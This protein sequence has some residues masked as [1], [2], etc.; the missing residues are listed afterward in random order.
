MLDLSVIIVSWN[1]RDLLRDCLR[2][3]QAHKPNPAEVI[4]ID[5]ASSDGSPD[6][7]ARE[8]PDVRLIRNTKNVGF[9]RAN[10]QGIKVSH[11]QYIAL[12]NS[13]IRTTAGALKTLV[14]FMAETPA[15]GA[16]GP[17]L[18]QPDGHPQPYAFGKDPTLLYLLHRGL[19]QVLFRR[20]LHDWATDAVQEVDWISG[21]C[22]MV[23]REVIDQVGLLDEHF[24]MYFE[25][26]DWCLRIRKAGWKVYYNPHAEIIHLGGQSL[27]QNPAAQE[28][29]YQSLHYFYAKHYGQLNVL[30]LDMMLPIYR[31]F[32]RR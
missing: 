30:L 8:F 25:D 12:L 26:N 7:V 9:A 13:D 2:S 14:A 4:V 10:N 22:L 18:L 19:Q 5:N 11:G 15:A 20:Y 27:V 3:L 29:Y 16:C 23:R 31:M 32:M 17:C 1:T 21:A 24:F 28:A 6:M